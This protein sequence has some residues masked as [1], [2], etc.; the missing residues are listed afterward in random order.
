MLEKRQSKSVDRG[1]DLR[2]PTHNHQDRQTHQH[3]SNVVEDLVGLTLDVGET[4]STI[5]NS[6]EEINNTV[7]VAKA[8]QKPSVDDIL[9]PLNRTIRVEGVDMM[10]GN[11][12][13][14]QQTQAD[15]ITQ[16]ANDVTTIDIIPI[17][18]TVEVAQHTRVG[19]GE[20]K[21][22]TSEDH[23]RP[24]K[25]PKKSKNQRPK[26]NLRVR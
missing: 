15:T 18:M 6:I 20:M 17:D 2:A 24:C 26:L 7:I 23:P 1:Q 13:G 11:V 8:D 9:S 12:D 19:D 3:P 22:L 10:S 4:K 21:K 14:G 5:V 25:S 16:V